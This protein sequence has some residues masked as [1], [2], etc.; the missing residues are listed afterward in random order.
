V[1]RGARCNNLSF[2]ID[3]D[4]SRLEI[5]RS[6]AITKFTF[7]VMSTTDQVTVD[8]ALSMLPSMIT[9]VT[10]PLVTSC[11]HVVSATSEPNEPI[12]FTSLS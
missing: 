4:D 2:N 5:D 8:P 1:V 3:H 10:L 6:Q 9:T 7:H 12:A 11:C